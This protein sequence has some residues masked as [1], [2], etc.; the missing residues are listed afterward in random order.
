MSHRR[1]R[2]GPARQA[3]GARVVLAVEQ[4]GNKHRVVGAAEAF[5]QYVAR[6]QRHGPSRPSSPRTS[7]RRR[8]AR[9]STVARRPE[10]SRPAAPPAFRDRRPRRL[11][12]GAPRGRPSRRS[13]GPRSA[14]ARAWHGRTAVASTSPPRY[15][16]A[17]RPAA[18]VGSLSRAHAGKTPSRAQRAAHVANRH[19]ERG[20]LRRYG[21]PRRR[22][23]ARRPPSRAP[24]SPRARVSAPIR[25]ASWSV[26]D[27]RPARRRGPGRCREHRGRGP[28]RRGEPTMREGVG[29]TSLSPGKAAGRR[30]GRRVRR[31]RSASRRRRRRARCG[32]EA[33]FAAVGIPRSTVVHRSR[34]DRARW[35][36][37]TWC[38]RR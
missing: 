7:R 27:R 12:A 29:V 20:R 30:F 21:K 8:L 24:A 13:H 10:S 31:P 6:T 36:P 1:R 5:A 15:R 4:S 33:G 22:G 38:R 11:G 16:A 25:C 18:R 28:V 26:P 2:L 14:P 3:R 35:R 23:A 17:G 9:G 34:S 37:V 32:P 19:E